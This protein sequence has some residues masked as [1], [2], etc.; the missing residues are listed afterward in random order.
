VGNRNERPG[1][2]SAERIR[3]DGLAHIMKNTKLSISL[4]LS[5]VNDILRKAF[6][7]RSRLIL[8]SR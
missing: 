7:L 5:R 4:V 8:E 3:R 1:H 6:E 2:T